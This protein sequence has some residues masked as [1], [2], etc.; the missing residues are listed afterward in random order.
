MSIVIIN[1]SIENGDYSKA[2]V[3]MEENE[4]LS[5]LGRIIDGN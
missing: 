3:L 1:L 5:R 2:L 4:N